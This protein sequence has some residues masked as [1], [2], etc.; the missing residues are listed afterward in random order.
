MM[1]NADKKESSFYKYRTQ[2]SDKC[3]T[4]NYN[5]IRRARVVAMS[6]C[7]K[8]YAP[9]R[10]LPSKKQDAFAR[11]AER[12]C[13]NHACKL[14]QKKNESAN[15]ENTNF[16]TLYDLISNKIQRNLIYSEDD[17]G[18]EYLIDGVVKGDINVKQL[19]QMESRELRP[20]V[21]AAIYAEIEERRRQKVEK[22]YS[23]Q[24]ECFKCG[25]WK[26]TEFKIQDRALDEGAAIWI[27]C[28][29]EDCS[30]RWKL[31]S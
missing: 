10:E 8:R 1:E 11:R 23:S 13:Y 3:Y 21:S 15:W 27:T 18:S 14:A 2:L 31:A 5:N 28:E 24:H 19:G 22:K 12:S 17:P 6:C 25:G 26:T 30:N 29:M 9:F 20:H 7:M 4:D 16:V